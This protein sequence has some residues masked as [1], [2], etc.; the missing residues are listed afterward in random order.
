MR[1]TVC[2]L[3][4]KEVFCKSLKCNTAK[5]LAGRCEKINCWFHFSKLTKSGG[6]PK[7]CHVL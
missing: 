6:D 3:A 7:L 2:I 5:R 4:F 1:R